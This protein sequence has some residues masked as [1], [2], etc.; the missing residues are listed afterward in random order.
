MDLAH[1]L[2]AQFAAAMQALFPQLMKYARNSAHHSLRATA[3]GAM[4][5]AVKGARVLP[6]LEL[7]SQLFQLGLTGMTN[8]QADPDIQRTAAFL[9]GVLIEMGGNSTEAYLTNTLQALHPLF[10]SPDPTVI[11][12]A[13]GA[14]ARIITTFPASP[15][16]PIE[17]ILPTLLPALPLRKDHQEDEPVWRCVAEL[18]TSPKVNVQGQGE[19]AAALL[20]AIM[21]GME[22][23][24]P[25]HPDLVDLLRLSLRRWLPTLQAL[26][27]SSNPSSSSPSSLTSLLHA[28][29]SKQL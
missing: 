21:R 6:P 5:E 18:T 4:A 2:G 26:S 1:A 24:P 7:M 27:S 16:V 20:A 23:D 12:N 29:A 14:V 22:Q 11:D 9:C 17:Y 19:T 10:A 25:L 28:L 8:R 3:I 13:C 15:N